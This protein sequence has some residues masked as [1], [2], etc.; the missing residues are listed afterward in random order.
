MSCIVRCRVARLEI[1]EQRLR[2]LRPSSRVLLQTLRDEPGNRVR[3]VRPRLR[4]RNGHR[5]NVSSDDLVRRANCET[6]ASRRTARRRG[7]RT[8]RCPRDDRSRDHPAP[9]RAP[10][11]PAFR[12]PT[13][14]A[15]A[16]ARSPSPSR[17]GRSP[18]AAA[19]IALAMPKSV[20][21]AAPPDSITLSGFTSRWTT[22]CSCAY[23]SARA[24]SRRTLTHSL[25]GSGPSAQ[26]CAQRRPF[27]VRHDEVQHTVRIT[28]IVQRHDVRVPEPRG[29]RDLAKEAFAA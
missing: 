15:S 27:L 13:P 12:S 28:R 11:T 22:P 5:P 17:S 10:C 2:T 7:S 21:T 24:T 14:T 1:G 9:A 29:D 19:A 23:A 4:E 16:V 26:A 20:T 6:A 25:T 3:N 8:N 18:P